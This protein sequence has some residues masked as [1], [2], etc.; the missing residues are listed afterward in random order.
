MLVS[1][2]HTGL[3]T[4]LD[5]YVFVN[6]NIASFLL[7]KV[8]HRKSFHYIFGRNYELLLQKKKSLKRSEMD[9]SHNQAFEEDLTE[10]TVTHEIGTLCKK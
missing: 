5:E 3:C 6:S 9:K 1:L 2:P 4:P 7:S 10:G 8:F